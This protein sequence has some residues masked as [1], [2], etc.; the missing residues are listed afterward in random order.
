MK[1]FFKILTLTFIGLLMTSCE[2]DDDVNLNVI[3]NS[4][5]SSDATTLVL[6]KDTEGNK[7]VKFNWENPTF[8]TQVVIKE[9]MEIA[10]AGSNFQNAASVNLNTL[11]KSVTYT[12]GAFNKI[13]LDAGFM[14]GTASAI[15]VRMKSSV[16]S[17]VLYSNVIKMTVTPYLT[18]FPSFYIVGDASAIG[19]SAANAQ[20]LYKQE[21]MSTIYT[22]LEN[23][24]SFR[25]LGQQDWGPA[26][27]SLDAAGTQ[28]GNKY[29][30][31]W[32][33][34][35]SVA[36]AENIK[37]GGASGMYKITI[38]SDGSKKTIDVV[39][40]AIT[41]WN[42]AGL[43]LVGSVNGWDAGSAIA[44][45]SL[46]NGKFEHTI[47]LSGETQL[48]FLGQQAWGDLEWGDSKADSN[49]GYLAPKGDNGNIKL[50]GTGGNYKITVDLKVGVY[51]IKPL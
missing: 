9:V 29:F 27:Y 48:K 11:D 41:V 6:T 51:S 43:Y 32:S 20:L 47:A 37:F 35:L 26:N 8:N 46:G 50:N 45:T 12:V 22:Y 40:S 15:E 44:M 21:N 39:A 10:A 16:G 28:A 24:K 23:G 17:I 25:F 49:T 18:A 38:D 34:N 42:P 5:L 7:A 4:S 13:I 30:K 31:T 36:D 1:H 3:S 2:K 14:P 19:W 33:T